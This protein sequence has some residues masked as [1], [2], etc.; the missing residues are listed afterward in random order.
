MTVSDAVESSRSVHKFTHRM[1][2]RPLLRLGL[3]LVLALSIET[4]AAGQQ[5]M[6]GDGRAPDFETPRPIEVRE[7][8]WI[9]EMTWLEARDAIAAGK[10][11]I[12]VGTGGIEQNGPY[13]VSGKHNLIM[14]ATGEAIARKLGNALL[15]PV[16]PFVPE[17]AI[18]P[19]DGYMRYPPTI[20]VEETTYRALLRDVVRSFRAHGFR[21][22]ILMGDSGGNQQGLEAVANE[23]DARWRDEDTRVIYVPEFYDWEGRAQWLRDRGYS[24][25]PEGIHDELS[26]QAIL[27]SVDPNTVR[28]SERRKAGRTS[29]NGIDIASEAEVAALGRALIEHIADQTVAAIKARLGEET[30]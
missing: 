25:I 8:L 7:S 2:D 3:L 11:T 13:T 17:G 15:A 6:M 29:I 5:A 26:V 4:Y 18:D 22:I 12:I 14:A 28:L 9:E 24:E 16:V 10:D 30:R 19:P 21:T 27:M 23:L 20:S 1:V